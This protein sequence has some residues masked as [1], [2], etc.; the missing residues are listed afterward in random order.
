MQQ[1]LELRLTPEVAYVPLRLT[2]AVST[3]LGIDVNRI[4]EVRIR[5]RSIDARQRNVMVNLSVDVFID[6]APPAPEA[7]LPALPSAGS[8]AEAKPIVIVGAGPAGLFAALKAIGLGLRPIVLERGKSV[9]E[10]SKDMARIA[11][12]N[13]VDPESNYCFGEG[14]AGAYSDGKLYTRSKKRGSVEEVLRLFVAHGASPEILVD[15]HP[16]I[17]TDRLPQVIRAIRESIIRAGGEVHFSTRVDR[18]RIATDEVGAK[19]VTGVETADGTSYEGPVILATGHSARDVYR[20]L[21]ADGIAIEPKGIAVGVRLEHPQNLIDR[22]QYH[23]PGGRGKYLPAAEYSMLTR[24]DGRAVYSFCMCPGGFIIPAATGPEQLVVNGMSPASRGTKW[25]NSG[26]VVEVL[27]EDL[28]EYAEYGSLRVMAFQEAIEKSFFDEAKGS[29][30]APAQRMHDF[31]N[32]KNSQSLPSTSY[33]PGIHPARI[34]KLLPSFIAQR[35]QKGFAEFGRKSR[36]FLTNDA[37][38]IGAETR[39]SSPVRIPRMDDSLQHIGI[40]GLFPCGEGAGYAGGIVS[41][42][43]DGMRCATA[44]ADYLKENETE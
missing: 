13:I 22:I 8:V 10:R 36:G 39:T 26:M 17:G 11:R 18:L 28:E 34:D 5:R 4:T 44:A 20:G 12:E 16:H 38:L 23:N 14:G 37:V 7:E 29:Q 32:S 35:L 43:I 33:A 27:P 9:E 24:V 25:A 6:D 41:A 42:A 31:V 2:A 21:L 15:A 1:T 40:S 19:R 3:R 30:N